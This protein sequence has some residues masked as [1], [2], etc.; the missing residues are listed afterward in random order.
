[1]LVSQTIQVAKVFYRYKN[2]KIANRKSVPVSDILRNNRL[3]FNAEK[4]HI[5]F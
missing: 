1:M 4:K 5:Y 2:D 3:N